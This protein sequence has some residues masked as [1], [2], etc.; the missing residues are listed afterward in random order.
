MKSY[1]LFMTTIFFFISAIANDAKVE[2]VNNTD[3]V[4]KFKCEVPENTEAIISAE[5]TKLDP[6]E[7]LFTGIYNDSVEEIENAIKAG[8]DINKQKEGKSPLLYALELKK[9]NAFEALVK[10]GA[11][12]YDINL[13][14]LAYIIILN[15]KAE[16]SKKQIESLTK[17][18]RDLQDQI[19]KK[20][21]IESDFGTNLTA[22][23]DELKQIQ[24]EL[25]NLKAKM[26][27]NLDR[28]I[29]YLK[30]RIGRIGTFF[31]GC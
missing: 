6:Q 29:K 4:L 12:V 20:T 27:I 24:Q 18:I 1:I 3:Q 25:S 15:S 14:L 17:Q 31:P 19:D 8:A 7:L 23:Q 5:F 28:E 11:S 21:K 26:P 16:S 10:H 2:I 9:Q 22:M 13:K 30:D